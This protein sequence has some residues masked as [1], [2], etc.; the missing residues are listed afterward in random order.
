[1]NLPT[2]LPTYTVIVERPVFSR[3]RRITAVV[4]EDTAWS[5]DEARQIAKAFARQYPSSTEITIID[6]DGEAETYPPPLP[7]RRT[8]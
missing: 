6:P 3:D 8:T 5:A 4:A 1:M 2:R 7:H